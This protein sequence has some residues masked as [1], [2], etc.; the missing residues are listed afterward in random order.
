MLL[1]LNVKLVQFAPMASLPPYEVGQIKARA[2]HGLGPSEISRLVKRA[3]DSAICPQT[4]SNHIAW[5]KAFPKWRGE[6]AQGS[7]RKRKT[8][9]ALDKKILDE[10]KKNRGKEKATVWYIKRKNKHLRCCSDALVHRRLEEAGYAY[11]PRMG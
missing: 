2:Y 10:V 9:V 7:G 11:L 4:I 5:L 6:R 1:P 3:D 8:S